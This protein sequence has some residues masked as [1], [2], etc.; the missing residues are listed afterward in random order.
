[1]MIRGGHKF[2]FILKFLVCMAG[3]DRG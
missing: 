2:T 1:M 3:Q